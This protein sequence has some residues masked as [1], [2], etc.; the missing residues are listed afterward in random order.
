VV[1]AVVENLA[2]TI[3]KTVM[4]TVTG[5]ITSSVNDLVSNTIINPV[6]HLVAG[7]TSVDLSRRLIHTLTHILGKS[8]PHIIVPSLVN[9]LSIGAKEDY[10]CYFCKAKSRY[11]EYCASVRSGVMNRNYYAL[12]YTGY[13]T[14]Y[15]AH[16]Y[17]NQETLNG[18]MT[19]QRKTVVPLDEV[20]DSIEKQWE[21]GRSDGYPEPQPPPILANAK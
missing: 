20:D 12:Y 6:T 14:N 11:C 13:H 5:P 1:G 7:V 18:A 17:A 16:Y 10:Y 15:Y 4:Q 21:M 9:T 3:G 2:Q 8:I 19:V